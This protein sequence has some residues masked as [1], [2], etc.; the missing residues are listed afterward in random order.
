ML[1]GR[2]WVF[3]RPLSGFAD[4]LVMLDFVRRHAVRFGRGIVLDLTCGGLKAPFD[5]V[6]E[7]LP[8]FGCVVVPYTE[9]L[10]AALDACASVRP[11]AL[12]GR[13]SDLAARFEPE[14]VN[15]WVD[16]VSGH[17]L[18]F[19]MGRDHPEQVLVHAQ[20]GGGRE[21]VRVLRHLRFTPAMAQAL[22]RRLA[23][24]GPDFDAV[25][26]RNSDYRTDYL[27]F[28]RR[29]APLLQGRTV[30]LCTDSAEVQAAARAVWGKAAQVVA[31]T[32]LAPDGNGDGR[33]IHLRPAADPMRHALD[34]LGDLTALA[35]ARR[36]FF[37][38]LA[39]REEVWR[40]RYSGFT[41][42]A[43]ALRRRPEV[44]AGLFSAAP[45]PP[46]QVPRPRFGLR[47]QAAA[48]GEWLWNPEARLQ[49]H[50]LDRRLHKLFAADP[51]QPV[52]RNDLARPSDIG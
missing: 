20:S 3:C 2:R 34:L 6:F 44:L 9:T 10:G 32:D 1:S 7:P 48:L 50:I 24:L 40:A 4:N 52:P 18:T 26:V 15:N 21:G 22:A 29:L 43:L 13:L 39:H 8:S 45:L 30:V 41:I 14:P 51:L 28:L 49:R 17:R 25:H 5:A 37:T 46:A 35:T 47:L 11:A 19:A 33:P 42:V 38:H 12:T 23:P 16:P 27:P 36:M 31:A